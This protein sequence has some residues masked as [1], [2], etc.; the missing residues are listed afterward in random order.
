MVFYTNQKLRLSLHLVH[1][2][3][4]YLVGAKIICF[5]PHSKCGVKIC[6]KLLFYSKESL[7]LQSNS[8]Y[9]YVA[10]FLVA[11]IYIC[12]ILKMILFYM[13]TTLMPVKR[14]KKNI[15]T[16]TRIMI[17]YNDFQMNLFCALYKAIK[18]K[19]MQKFFK[20]LTQA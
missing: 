20:R 3:L 11:Y 6:I 2:P 16:H 9:L 4:F 13:L 17:K 19:Y 10:F 12:S 15:H 14:K 18:T 7:D 8:W 5:Y 1:L